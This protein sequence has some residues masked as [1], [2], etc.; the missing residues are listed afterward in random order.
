MPVGP[1]RK[2]KVHVEFAKPDSPAPGSVLFWSV[3]GPSTEKNATALLRY[4]AQTVQGAFA[5]RELGGREMVVLQACR[6]LESLSAAEVNRT[7]SAI[8]WQ[9]DQVEQKLGGE[10]NY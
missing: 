6:P 8:A 3:C 7:L 10:D 9:A 4:N 1:L 5:I 2:Q